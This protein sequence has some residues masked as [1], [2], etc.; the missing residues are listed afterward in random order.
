[1]QSVMFHTHLHLHTHT[2][3]HTHKHTHIH[4]YIHTLWWSLSQNHVECSE[5]KCFASPNASR[6]TE[7]LL[8]VLCLHMESLPLK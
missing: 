4:T 5:V 7:A 8:K 1:M 2:H 3:L 6:P